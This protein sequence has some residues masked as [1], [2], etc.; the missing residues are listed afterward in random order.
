MCVP[1]AAA[2]LAAAAAHVAADLATESTAVVA[3]AEALL[4]PDQRAAATTGDDAGC[5]WKS[6]DIFVLNEAKREM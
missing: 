3:V 6:K 5:I 4:G 2:L 1:V